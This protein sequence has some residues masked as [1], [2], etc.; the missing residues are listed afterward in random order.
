MS[1]QPVTPAPATKV[2]E[3]EQKQEK[4]DRL[5]MANE[6]ANLGFESGKSFLHLQRV[7]AMFAASD[8]VPD[9]FRGNIANCS[10]A[11]NLARRLGADELM[12]MQ[13]L[14]VVYGRPGWSSKF[15]IAMFNQTA[16]FTPITYEFFGQKGT[17]NYGCRAKC[18]NRES[19][20][21]IVGPDITIAL[22]KAE[23]W[24]DRVSK[25]GA[26]ASKWPTMTDLMLR[27]RSASWLIDTTAPE[28]TMGL[29]TVE[30]IIDTGEL[31]EQTI[32]TTE[33][34]MEAKRRA[35]LVAVDAVKNAPSKLDA[36]VD[37]AKAAEPAK[38]PAAPSK[39][40][41]QPRPAAQEQPKSSGRGKARAEAP[42]AQAVPANS[43]PLENPNYASGDDGDPF[44]SNPDLFGRDPGQEG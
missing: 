34:R 17:D 13:N 31:L 8:L 26:R 24:W 3:A 5:R 12:V 33:E 42:P 11:V 23:G 6:A 39:P 15:K 18:T 40:A 25:T 36:L 37:A 22:A 43:T 14:Y 32:R 21:Q 29:H 19:G 1:T 20:E 4:D 9:A 38:E 30:E 16:R 2:L 35:E 10:I 7:A 27:Y 28:L 44:K 41:D